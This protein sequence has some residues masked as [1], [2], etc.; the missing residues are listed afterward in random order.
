[1]VLGGKCR[2]C[3]RVTTGVKTFLMKL[4]LIDLQ[5]KTVRYEMTAWKAAAKHIFGTD[6]A[7]EVAKKPKTEIEDTLD[8]WAL[9]PVQIKALVEYD[10]VKGEVR[11]VPFE[12]KKLALDYAT[13]YASDA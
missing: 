3:D 12:I 10:L 6:S 8:T 13:E 9:I 1:M 4:H 11:T 5:D 7:T 2:K